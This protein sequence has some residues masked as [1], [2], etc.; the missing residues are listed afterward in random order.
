MPRHGN[1]AGLGGSGGKLRTPG[2][3]KGLGMYQGGGEGGAGEGVP[4]LAPG[5]RQ[6]AGA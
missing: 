4:P 2:A 3:S 5:T 6:L 1:G